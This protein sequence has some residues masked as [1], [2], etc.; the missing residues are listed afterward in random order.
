[1]VRAWTFSILLALVPVSAFAASKVTE[2]PLEGGHKLVFTHPSAWTGE[3]KGPAIG[4]T[5]KLG[6]SD[7]GDFSV[8]ITA[9]PR[10][11]GF[12]KDDQELE[13][14]TLQQGQSQLPGAVQTEL[15]LTRIEGQEA[16]GSFYHLTDK[17]P[18]RGPGDWREAHQ[19]AVVLGGYVLSFTI[20]THTDDTTT[21]PAALE[22]LRTVHY[23]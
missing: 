14:V 3:I 9:I 18:E 16:K 6:P 15:R 7:S 17:N 13:K 10:M 5:L 21:V 23:Q 11:N 19:G 12:P 22:V 2:I 1:M 20:L 4:P 8:L